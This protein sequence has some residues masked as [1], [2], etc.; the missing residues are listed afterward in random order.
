M[1]KRI[2]V[3]SVLL[4]ILLAVACS[5]NGSGF[6]KTELMLKVGTRNI[7]VFAKY[8]NKEKK[9]ISEFYMVYDD[10]GNESGDNMKLAV[11]TNGIIRDR[12]GNIILDL[13]N[14]KN[15]FYGFVIRPSYPKNKRFAPGFNLDPYFGSSD[16]VGDTQRIQWDEVK[17][18]FQ[19]PPSMIP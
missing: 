12:Y 2:S 7:V 15:K 19:K 4:C 13:S 3:I 16:N 11:L 10:V 1:R 17:E 8:A 9:I 5:D 14:Y 6:E 18:T